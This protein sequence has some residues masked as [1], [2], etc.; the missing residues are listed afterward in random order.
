MKKQ[1]VLHESHRSQRDSTCQGT[2]IFVKFDD[3]HL[4]DKECDCVKHETYE[5]HDWHPT[6]VHLDDH[7]S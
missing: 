3:Q 1:T 7:E 2:G 5:V 4:V 6:A